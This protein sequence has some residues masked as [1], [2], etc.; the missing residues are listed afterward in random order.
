M[1]SFSRAHLLLGFLF[2]A[3]FSSYLLANPT[4][5]DNSVQ[6]VLLDDLRSGR[7]QKS[8]KV[9]FK[10]DEHVVDENGDI[11]IKR[12]TPA[13]GKIVRSRKADVLGLRGVLEVELDHTFSVEG[14]RVPLSGR[15]LKAGAKNKR[16]V[17][18]GTWLVA[19]PLAFVRG[20]NVVMDA[21][22]KVIARIDENIQFTRNQQR[23]PARQGAQIF[24]LKSGHELQGRIVEVAD[25]KFKVATSDGTLSVNQ[26]EVLTIKNR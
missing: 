24:R 13:F 5:R 18:W 7:A 10:V 3:L 4:M 11:L 22:T 23:P 1:S 2:S 17:H 9:H 8:S 21:G 26:N 16:L 12:G 20:D 19:L 25:G 6:L 14:E 15:K